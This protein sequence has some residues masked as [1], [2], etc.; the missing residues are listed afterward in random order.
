MF[1][2]TIREL[3]ML[4]VIGAMG[5]GWLLDRRWAGSG[6]PVLSGV[7][8]AGAKSTGQPLAIKPRLVIESE[9]EQPLT[10]DLQESP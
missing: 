4:T 7:P 10:I 5:I 3:L 8:Y 1:R 2:F 9:A 6:L